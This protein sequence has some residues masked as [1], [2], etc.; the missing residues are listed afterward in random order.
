MST[1]EITAEVMSLPLPDRVSL[2]QALWESIEAGFAETDEYSAV[3]E[4][5]R[6]D[7]EL[8]SDAAIGIRKDSSEN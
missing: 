1:Q 8:S 2:A 3:R 7:E 6:R 5:I 4:A